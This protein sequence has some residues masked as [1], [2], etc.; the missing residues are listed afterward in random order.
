MKSCVGGKG[1]LLWTK[2]SP[3]PHTP[4]ILFKKLSSLRQR[5]RHTLGDCPVS[6]GSL[7]TIVFPAGAAPHKGRTGG[8]LG[9]I[10]DCSLPC[11]LLFF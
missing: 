11:N 4:P 8:R 9:A 1:K 5:H 10:P 3:S 6:L 7:P 2:V